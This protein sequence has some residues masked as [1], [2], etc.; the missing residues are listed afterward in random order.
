MSEM[1]EYLIANPIFLVPIL[2]MA[3]MMIFAL[4]KKLLKVAAIAAIAGAMYLL[5]VEY[6]GGGLS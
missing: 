3:A 2:V 5:V 6:F 4:L 1:V